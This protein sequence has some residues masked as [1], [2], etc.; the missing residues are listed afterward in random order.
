MCTDFFPRLIVWLLTLML[1]LHSLDHVFSV[2][3]FLTTPVNHTLL[4]H[5]PSGKQ[6]LKKLII[7]T[8]SFIFF[9]V[10]SAFIQNTGS[11]LMVTDKE[12]EPKFKRNVAHCLIWRLGCSCGHCFLVLRVSITIRSF[13]CGGAGAGHLRRL[14]ARSLVPPVCLLSLLPVVKCI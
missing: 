14:V 1:K 6:G 2:L 7:L 5:V 12:Q 3:L 13:R 8:H 9:Q 4:S 10:L 11:S